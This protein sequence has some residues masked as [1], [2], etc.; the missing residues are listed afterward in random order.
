MPVERVPA[1]PAADGLQ[2]PAQTVCPDL[3]ALPLSPRV[4]LSPTLNLEFFL[5]L[6]LQLALDGP[7]GVGVTQRAYPREYSR[8][9]E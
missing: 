2:E 3:D 6:P 4:A 5:S 9:P 1:L 7:I 8:H